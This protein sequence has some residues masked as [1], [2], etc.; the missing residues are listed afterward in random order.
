MARSGHHRTDGQPL[1]HAA[2]SDDIAEK[3]L[4]RSRLRLRPTES[5][6]PTTTVSSSLL[7]PTSQSP[8]WGVLRP[9]HTFKDFRRWWWTIRVEMLLF[10]LSLLRTIKRVDEHGNLA[11]WCLCLAKTN[12]DETTRKWPLFGAALC[13]LVSGSAASRQAKS[14]GIFPCVCIIKIKLKFKL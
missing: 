14:D 4:L 6:C 10:S 12:K 5:T 8:G 7:L 9:A 13:R 11:A 3:D 1:L 2:R